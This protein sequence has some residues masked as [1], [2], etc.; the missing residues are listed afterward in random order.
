MTVIN[1]TPW[2]DSHVRIKKGVTPYGGRTMAVNGY[3]RWPNGRLEIYLVA[4]TATGHKRAGVGLDVR[5]YKE[6]E[7]EGL[8]TRR[9]RVLRERQRESPFIREKTP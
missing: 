7:V 1:E 5:I 8:P 3:K 2:L 6:H 9:L 4:D